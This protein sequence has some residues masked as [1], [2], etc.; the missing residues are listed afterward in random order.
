MA[1]GGLVFFSYL[2]VSSGFHF[3]K[4]FLNETILDRIIHLVDQ[5]IKSFYALVS[6]SPNL[7]RC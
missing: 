5:L 7:M 2:E 1:S 6:P 3:A 4:I